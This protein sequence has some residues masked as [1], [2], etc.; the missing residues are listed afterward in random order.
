MASIIGAPRH[1]AG[2]ARSAVANPEIA[3]VETA[4]H[5]VLAR[6]RMRDDDFSIYRVIDD[7]PISSPRAHRT[8]KTRAFS[9]PRLRSTVTRRHS[10]TAAANA[11]G[12]LP[13][14]PRKPIPAQPDKARKP[15][16]A[17][18]LRGCRAG[19]PHDASRPA[20]RRRP[21]AGEPNHAIKGK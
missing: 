4:P 20:Y 14:P 2:R 18:P 13:Q 16:R 21:P 5:R 19:P 6:L 7:M 9:L 15:R 1:R 10:A 12:I 3:I 11:P 8:R 17:A